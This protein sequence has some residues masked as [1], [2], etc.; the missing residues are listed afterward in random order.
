MILSKYDIFASEVEFD[1]YKVIY[2]NCPSKKYIVKEEKS[3]KEFIDMA[4]IIPI[5][6]LDVLL[7][8][9]KMHEYTEIES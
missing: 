6:L 4:N 9:L 1:K 8:G 2:V 5:E 7:S 3:I